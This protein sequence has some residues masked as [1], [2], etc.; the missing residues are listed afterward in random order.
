[1]RAL[2]IETSCD[3]TAVAV[4]EGDGRVVFNVISSQA[5]AHAPYLGVVPEIAARHH[6]EALPKLLAEADRQVGLAG[7]ELVAVT[8]GP[9][10]I[11]SLL[12]GTCFASAYAWARKLPL[13][14]V[15]H[16]E[17]HLVSPFLNL[18]DAPARG[19]V[20]GTLTLVISGGHSSY[21]LLA[22]G[23][24]RPLNRTRDDAAG[25]V[26]DKVA[27]A[28]GLGY[29]GGP[30]VDVLAERGD[31]ARF[32]FSRPRIKDPAGALDF[33]FSGL[34]TSVIRT[35][36]GLGQVPLPDP[37]KPPQAF[38]DLLASFQSTIVEWLLWPL[39]ELVARHAPRLVAASGGVAGNRELRRRLAAWG[40]R[41]GIEVL[42]PP[43]ALTT[44]NAAMIAWAGQTRAARGER[45]DPRAL[46]AY[47]R[48][49]WK[50]A[51]GPG[52]KPVF[53]AL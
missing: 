15:D 32:E 21:F 48:A 7:V 45:D 13:V 35:A 29:P 30:V 23:E 26:F 44:D 37:G 47:P 10:L 22:G 28:L 8:R 2:G 39:E 12:V 40:E 6:L 50:T 19:T 11:G 46:A 52:G 16:L 38:L 27:A 41:S 36:Q 31:P 4:L 20:E 53:P 1:M 25:E 5:A 49:P 51:G 34:K 3:E 33:S 14:G 24:A 42:L 9:G 43:V 18:E 17:G